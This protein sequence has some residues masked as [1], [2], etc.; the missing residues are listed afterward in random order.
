M[1]TKPMSLRDCDRAHIF[2]KNCV[3][4]GRSDELFFF[5]EC[6]TTC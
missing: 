4:A 2:S 6:E 3:C 5:S 1:S